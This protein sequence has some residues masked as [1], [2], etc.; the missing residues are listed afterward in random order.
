[1]YLELT[2]DISY[3]EPF[4]LGLTEPFQGSDPVYKVRKNCVKL[5]TKPRPEQLQ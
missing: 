1:M 2:P 4:F 3:K 5:K